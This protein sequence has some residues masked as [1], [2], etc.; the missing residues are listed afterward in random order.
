MCDE[1]REAGTDKDNVWMCSQGMGG[2]E[3]LQQGHEVLA[4]S[5]VKITLDVLYTREGAQRNSGRLHRSF[6]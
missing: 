6:R 4:F 5:H 1:V 2:R 3:G